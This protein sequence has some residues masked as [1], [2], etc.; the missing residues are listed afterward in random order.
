MP[1]LNMNNGPYPLTE[2]SINDN[3]KKKIGNYGV[4]FVQKEIFIIKY[5]GRSDTN[6]N[7]R[8]KDHIGKEEYFNFKFSYA[9]NA[10]MAYEKE[11]LNYHDFIDA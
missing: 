11:C 10:I 7:K 1:S 4:G 9:D 5:V 2:K 8:L 6:L 3:V